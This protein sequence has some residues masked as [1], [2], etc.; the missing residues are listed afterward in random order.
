MYAR[1][2][3][4][5]VGLWLVFAPLVLGYGS[6]G[7]ILH[8]VAVGL[9]VCIAALTSLEWPPA[10]FGLAVPALWL[11]WS[12]RKTGDRAASIVE[13]ASGVVLFLLALFPSARLVPPL[14]R[15]A[16]ERA[17]RATARP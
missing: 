14:A 9:L 3:T 16:A 6:V 12:A 10:R 13:V 11:A 1:W 7:P 2:A 15:G 4:F 5:A 17:G 8:H